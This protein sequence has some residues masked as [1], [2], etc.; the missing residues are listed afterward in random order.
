MMEEWEEDAGA[1]K[2]RVRWEDD[3]T[4]SPGTWS[5]ESD[6]I[7]VS[8]LDE[9]LGEG[10]A[11]RHNGRRGTAAMEPGLLRGADGL[12]LHR[13][14]QLTQGVALHP[15]NRGHLIDLFAREPALAVIV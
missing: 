13:A 2:I 4:E 9:P 5:T 3:G 15:S 6:A 14:Q 8:D 7:K 10:S 12:P 1:E 11:V